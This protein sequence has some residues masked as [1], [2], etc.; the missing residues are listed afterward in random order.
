M[1]QW[2]KENEFA[3]F[4]CVLVP[5]HSNALL[6]TTWKTVSNANVLHDVLTK[7]GQTQ[8][9]QAADSPLVQG[10]IAS[11][12]SP[13]DDNK[14]GDAILN[15]TFN[16]NGIWEMVEVKDI[17]QGMCYPDPKHPTPEFDTVITA[18]QFSRAIYN[19]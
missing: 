17:I 18:D 10:P 15:G 12:I 7:D 6:T 13:F 14:Y 11:F 8:Y 19:T 2:W 5:E 1:G 16:L 3:Q 9:R 4:T